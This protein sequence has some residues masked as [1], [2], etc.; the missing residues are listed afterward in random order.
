MLF[1]VMR[2]LPKR[3]I[4]IINFN[5]KVW[6]NF[7]KSNGLSSCSSLAY[8][9]LLAFIPFSV[10]IAS[11][12]TWLPV[13]EHIV[14]NV[15][16]YFF[17]QY[18]PQSGNQIYDLFQFSFKHTGHLSMLG[19][20]SLIV[21]CYAMMFSVEQHIH[22]MWHLRRQR[23]I[24]LS[25]SLFTGFFIGGT[26]F[27]Y[28]VAYF[29][30]FINNNVKSESFF[31][32]HIGTFSAN[33]ITMFSFISLYKFIPSVKV[34]WLHSIVAGTSASLAFIF[35]QLGFG[36]SM[37]YLQKDYEQLY[38]SLAMLPIFLLWLYLSVL[39][40]LLGAQIIYV[41]RTSPSKRKISGSISQ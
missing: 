17:S 26:I 18:I 6:R 32:Q 14:F 29:T 39:I 33:I 12:S 20:I 5:H 34:K 41:L 11:L 16:R 31:I 8:T 25:L 10:S 35:L 4:Q 23:K 40:L 24:I 36:L 9:F 28:I 27:V 15:E 2:I 21:T 37:N 13:S 22:Q 1:K 38:G 7:V 19:L 3:F 30:E